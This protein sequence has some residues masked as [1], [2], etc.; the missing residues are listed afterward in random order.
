MILPIVIAGGSGTRLWP[1]SRQSYPKQF[2]PLLEGGRS[3]LQE[4]ILRFA[5]ANFAEPWFICNEEHRFLVAEQ[6]RNI[7]SNGH[8]ILE[9]VGRN[10]APAIAIAALQAENI[11]EDAL[12]LVMPADHVIK[13]NAAFLQ[14]VEKA[15]VLADADQLVTFGITPTQPETG[16]GYIHK[17]SPIGN[18]GYQ[19]A[20]FIEKPALQKA[21]EYVA[22]GHYLWNSGIFMFKAGVYLDALK[23]TAPEIV[24]F[25][26]RALAGASMDHDFIRLHK[27]IFSECPAD[28]IDYAVMEKTSNAAVVELA[29]DWSDLGSWSSLWEM[30]EKDENGNACQGDTIVQEV[31]QSL[32]H[33]EHRLVAV[34]G[35]E[36]VIVIET[37]DAVLVAAKDK[38]Q[39]IKSIVNTIKNDQRHEHLMHREVYRPWGSYDSIDIGS[40]YQVK[41]ITVN[42]GARLSTQMHFHRAEHWVVVSGTAKVSC[43]EK[44]FMLTENQSTFIPVG[45]VHALENPGKVPLE[46]IE[47]QSGGYLGEDDIVRFDDA[48][49]RNTEKSET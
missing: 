49:G 22:D 23:K 38:V 43:G 35:V 30:R 36:N 8:I 16:Y 12:L 24:S 45:E 32:V 33:A 42:P 48:Y 27:D 10:T 1:L 31:Q 20:R 26:E 28:S 5:K 9:P 7:K 39:Q 25:C 17:G 29:T 15:Q 18:Q 34:V 6:L 19:V 46:L 44:T 37:K 21:T 13:D 2:L 14:A 4:T 3:L 41:R 40:R 11:H 47:V